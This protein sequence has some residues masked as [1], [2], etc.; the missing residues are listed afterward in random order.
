ISLYTEIHSGSPG[1]W[2]A[3]AILNNLLDRENFT[4]DSAD[5]LLLVI[6][7]LSF[8]PLVAALA[9]SKGKPPDVAP[10]TRGSNDNGRHRRSLLSRIFC[11]HWLSGRCSFD[12]NISRVVYE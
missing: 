11:C 9:I 2:T 10:S 7:R 3:R 6:S 4:Q 5:I 12:G 1:S 8:L